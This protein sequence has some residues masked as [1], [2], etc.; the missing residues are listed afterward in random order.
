MGEVSQY[1]LSD[2]FQ[3]IFVIFINR[4]SSRIRIVFILPSPWFVLGNAARTCSVR[5]G[6]CSTFSTQIFHTPPSVLERRH[7]ADGAR[8]YFGWRCF[9]PALLDGLN[10]CVYGRMGVHI[11]QETEWR[12]V[13]RNDRHPFGDSIICS[14]GRDCHW[15]FFWSQIL[16]ACGT[17][18][19]GCGELTS[20]L[21]GYIHIKKEV[22]LP[23]LY[24]FKLVCLFEDFCCQPLTSLLSMLCCYYEGWCE[25]QEILWTVWTCLFLHSYPCTPSYP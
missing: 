23:H 10:G 25:F 8:T 13:R 12:V 24:L 5:T 3:Y 20:F 9:L 2:D 22:S 21:Y 14:V 17:D 4:S 7:T 15:R 18:C 6:L 11:E 16:C 1:L 19:T